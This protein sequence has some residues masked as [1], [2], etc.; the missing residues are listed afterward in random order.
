MEQILNGRPCSNCLRSNQNIAYNS[1]A[2]SGCTL[3]GSINFDD[4]CVGF[5]LNNLGIEY[6]QGPTG[7]YT[8]TT[9][10]GLVIDTARL[11][12]AFEMGNEQL[13][14]GSLK[15]YVSSLFSKSASSVS[16]N[17]RDIL[18]VV[19]GMIILFG[20]ILYTIICIILIRYQV[21]DTAMG[22]TAIF[23]GLFVSA[24]AFIIVYYEIRS[25]TNN[26]E[27]LISNNI[28]P[29]LDNLSCALHS[30]ICCYSGV[31]C[32]CPDGS[33]TARCKNSLHP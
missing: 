25:L 29:F 24:L 30:A 16:T 3:C 11:S 18:I 32:C 33:K 2:S 21:M 9:P 27:E 8:F 23:I 26:I 22:I 20:F 12:N 7:T 4:Y 31:S 6:Y 14:T 1:L 13:P 5:A 10:N 15:S 19:L 28:D 17:V